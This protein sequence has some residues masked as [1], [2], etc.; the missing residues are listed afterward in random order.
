MP[1]SNI[2]EVLD[3]VLEDGPRKRKLVSEIIRNMEKK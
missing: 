1:V 2:G 3:Y